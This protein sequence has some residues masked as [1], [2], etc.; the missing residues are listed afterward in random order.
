[1]RNTTLL[2][3][4][5]TAQIA[6][7]EPARL[8]SSDDDGSN[9]AT[10]DK[11]ITA[12]LARAKQGK[13]QTIVLVAAA[14]DSW[15]CDCLPFVYG[16]YATSAPEKGETFFFPIAKTGADPGAVTIG[17]SA[18]MY[19]LTGQFTKER[20]TEAAWK[21]RRKVKGKGNRR[22]KQPVFAVESWC[23]RKEADAAADYAEVFMQMEK[24]GV[25]FCR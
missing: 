17:S 19:E 12:E 15:G 11:K 24:A 10:I 6:Y 9:P 4:V 14:T 22:S 1:M 18:G 5:L 2:T 13:A 7:A 21:A 23:F 25:T 3:S 16:P 20:I 8:F